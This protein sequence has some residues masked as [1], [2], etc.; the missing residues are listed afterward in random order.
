MRP[1]F[2]YFGGKARLARWITGWFP[3]HYVYLEP[4]CGSA[5][6]LLAK[7]R[8]AHEII[9]DADRNVVTFYRMLRDRPDDLARAC[10][11]T[12]YARDELAAAEAAGIDMVS[13]PPEMLL[14]G[15]TASTA[16]RWPRAISI[17]PSVSM[18]IGF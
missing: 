3:E 1:P 9:N 6:V 7:R 2:R 14:D 11:L 8:C 4:F 17:R 5:A 15:S 13:V 18:S 16:T 12:P 10:A